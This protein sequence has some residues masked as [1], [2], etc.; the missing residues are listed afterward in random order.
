[1]CPLN[2]VRLSQC[3]FPDLIGP[4]ILGEST[5]IEEIRIKLNFGNACYH[6]VQN[7]LSSHLLSTNEMIKIL[8]VVL[9]ECEPWSPALRDKHRLRVSENRFLRVIY[10]PNRKEVIG[11][12]KKLHNDELHNLHFTT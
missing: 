1:L 9:Y 10:G 6:S 4:N 5:S 3:N 2:I 7:L 8:P 11:G 12:W